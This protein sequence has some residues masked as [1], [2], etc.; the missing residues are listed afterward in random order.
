MLKRIIRYRMRNLILVLTMLLGMV[1]LSGA[2]DFYLD[3]RTFTE[4]MTDGVVVTMWGYA[5]CTAGFAACDPPTAPGPTL[6]VPPTDTTVNITVR[7][8]LTGPYTEPTSLMIPGQQTTMVPVP[9]PVS[10]RVRS[11]TQ[12]V[13]VGASRTYTWTN[14]KPGTYLYQSAT[15]PGLQVQMGLA[16][17]IKKDSA[18]GQA[19]TGINYNTDVVLVF[20]EIDPALH[21]AVATGNYGP[22]M[23]VTSTFHYV[24]KYFL[25]N[26]EPFTYSRSAILAGNPGETTLLRFLNAG[27]NDYTPLLQGLYMS[28]IAEDGNL[29]PFP[30]QQYSVNLPAGKT[31]DATIAAPAAPGYYPLYDRRLNLTNAQTGPGGMLIFLNFAGPQSTLNVTINGSGTVKAT[32]A[33]GG[34]DCGIDC[35]ESYNTGTV[36]GLTAFPDTGFVFNG[37]TG[38]DPGTE[39][40]P[41]AT[42]T[43]AA[44]TTVTASFVVPGAPTN[45]LTLKRPNSGKVKKSKPKPYKI[46][47]KFTVDPGPSIRIDLFQNDLFV[48]N[49]AAAA[50]AGTPNKKGKGKGVYL[51]TVDPTIPDGTGY[52]VRITSTTNSTYTDFSNKTFKIVP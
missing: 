42:V 51:W 28:A 34:I 36:V 21:E 16:G 13:A 19:Y 8:S 6:T 24:P 4:T 41:F 47:W 52:K 30:K 2:A 15:H 29:I 49:I 11:F 27:I 25:I 7:N 18:A 44:N 17:A 39:N 48:T 31:V 50:P 38:V 3:T 45:Y 22:G 20:S 40:I 26:G 5:N 9:D 46:K 37:W 1:G 10:G 14:F 23:A 43:L 32:G 12:E 35:S 33:P